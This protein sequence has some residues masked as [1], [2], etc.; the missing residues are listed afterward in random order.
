MNNF[1]RRS[2]TFKSAMLTLI[3]FAAFT[4][5]VKAGDQSALFGDEMVQRYVNTASAIIYVPNLTRGSLLQLRGAY[6]SAYFTRKAL[7]NS[8]CD[9]APLRI[10]FGDFDGMSSGIS[11]T[12]SVVLMVMNPAIADKLAQGDDIVGDDVTLVDINRISAHSL[13]GVDIVVAGAA[14]ANSGMVLNPGRSILNDLFGASSA[15]NSCGHANAAEALTA[16]ATQN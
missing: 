12:G 15:D 5:N 14:S 16:S 13:E 8:W 6:G 2:I 7:D 3:I 10:L 1:G 9:A 11:R 4:G